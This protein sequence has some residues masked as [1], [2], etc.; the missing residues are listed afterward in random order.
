MDG[1]LERSKYSRGKLQNFEQDALCNRYLVFIVSF[2][3]FV[4]KLSCSIKNIILLV[5]PLV[6]LRCAKTLF[7]VIQ[8]V[9]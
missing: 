4:C 9:G 2:S 3:P 5:Y 6:Y 1:S 7:H 8:A